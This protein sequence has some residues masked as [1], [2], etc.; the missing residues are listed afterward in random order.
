MRNTITLVAIAAILSSV[1]AT[2]RAEKPVDG[3]VQT[4]F[5]DELWRAVEIY[6]ER[7]GKR[8][9]FVKLRGRYHGQA[10][11]I[12]GVDGSEQDSENRRIRLGLDLLLTEK[13]EFAFDLNL[14]RDGSGQIV[15]NFD[16]LAFNY[17][18][19]K[20]TALSFGKLRRN[21]L[22]REDSISSNKILTI[23]RSILTSRNFIDNAGGVFVAH[24]RDDWAFGGGVLTGS[25]DP[26]NFNLPTFDGSLLFK[27]NVAKQIS[28]ITEIR[29]DYLYNPGD[30]DNN[31]VEPFR[32]VVS[33][34]SYTRSGRWGLI[35]DLIYSKGL[36]E[37]RGNLFGL[38]V[39]P[40]YMLTDR[41]QVVGRYTYTTSN[42]EDGI[43]LSSRYE[44]R[45][46]AAGDEFGDRHQ[47]L[48]AGLNYYIYGHKLKLV[49]GLEYT[50]FEGITG[51]ESFLTGSVALRFYF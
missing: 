21:P 24:Q 12:D 31:E 14:R 36:E 16:F 41:L 6:G 10:F 29:L 25:S 45:A 7:E 30:R 47:S 13:L 48:Y 11:S 3:A 38:V 2:A 34:N 17:A 15:D 33:L 32:N 35:T 18:F 43:R 37:A 28:P 46:I 4:E 27:G 8:F 1:P 26:D 5:F 40:H 9:P 44:R 22:T 50:N 20:N 19:S 49:S 39:L 42:S 51:T 23:E